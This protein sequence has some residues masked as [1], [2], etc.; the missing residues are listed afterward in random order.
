MV[1]SISPPLPKLLITVSCSNASYCLVW[2]LRN[3][4]DIHQFNQIV[5]YYQHSILHSVQGKIRSEDPVVITYN[6]VLAT[7]YPVF[8]T[9]DCVIWT[10]YY[11]VLVFKLFFD[12]GEKLAH[13]D[14]FFEELL[15]FIEA[16]KDL[17]RTFVDGVVKRV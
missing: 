4:V 5:P 15:F 17:E 6:A 10:N 13:R 8:A 1:G 2:I 12:F 7:H 11:V 9:I 16:T 3:P 14:A